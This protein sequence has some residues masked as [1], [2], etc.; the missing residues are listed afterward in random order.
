MNK[1]AALFLFLLVGV[2]SVALDTH[3]QSPTPP[4]S[5]SSQTPGSRQDA[6]TPQ[7][8]G[9]GD[10]RPIPLFGKLTAIHEQSLDIEK[11]NG[12]S[13]TVKFSTETQFRKERETAKLSDFKVG[14]I[15]FVRGQENPDHTWTAQA[16]GTR[17]AG[18]YGGGSGGGPG[19]GPMG[20]GQFGT[21][22]K[23][24]LIGEVKATDAP[25]LTILRVDNV[26]QT[27]ELNEDSSLR[28]GRE[29]IT[30]AD[31]QPG[32]HAIIRGAMNGEVFVPKNVLVIGPEQWK[33][34]QEMGMISGPLPNPPKSDSQ[35]QK[36]GDQPH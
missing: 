20:G 10:G 24:F 11:P 32:D 8:P 31:V 36:P 21:L 1:I 27:I 15:V 2:L 34:M 5:A 12:E 18:G 3:A 30:M 35:P 33:R 9:R 29:S 6:N 19:G 23:D 22:G 25:K 17:P 14:D 28:R 7:S 13:V 16:I 4:D 26:T